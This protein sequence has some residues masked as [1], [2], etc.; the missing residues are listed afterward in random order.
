MS[1]WE[2]MIVPAGKK[3]IP[4]KCV[5][6]RKL[7]ADGSTERYKARVVIK[8]FY[9]RAGIDYCAVCAPVVCASTVRLFFSI[10]ASLDLIC[11]AIDIKYDFI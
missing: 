5:F 11:H 6:K 7:H 1:A 8:G 9:Q 4:C 2:L 10:M 3:S